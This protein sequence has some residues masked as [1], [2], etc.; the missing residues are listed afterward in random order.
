MFI[1]PESC[2][3]KAVVIRKFLKEKYNIDI[4]QGHGLEI[5]SKYL[6]LRIG[7]QHQQH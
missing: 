2:K 7:I 3:E 4:S 1:S 6:V 5:V